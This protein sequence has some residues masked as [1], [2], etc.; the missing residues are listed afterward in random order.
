[1]S[2]CIDNIEGEIPLY[3]FGN[4]GWI[5][6]NFCQSRRVKDFV[7]HNATLKNIKLN[8]SSI[9]NNVILTMFS[10]YKTRKRNH[11]LNQPRPILESK[12]IKHIHNSNFRDKLTKYFFLSKKYDIL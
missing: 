4:S 12:I 6:Y 9:I 1:M 5:Y 2:I 11:L 8:S 3:K 10:K 7:F